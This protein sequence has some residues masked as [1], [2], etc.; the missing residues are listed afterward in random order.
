LCPVP[1]AILHSVRWNAA[2]SGRDAAGFDVVMT[3]TQAIPP[4]LGRVP[5]RDLMTA[6]YPT[7]AAIRE[8]TPAFAVENNGYRMWVITR[9]EDVRQVLSDPSVRRDLVAHRKEINSHCL[10]RVQQR[11]HLPHGSRRSF[12]DRDG[13]E[14][15][16]LRGL[17]GNIFSPGRLVALRADTERITAELLDKLPVGEPVDL[18]DR[19]ARP[20]AGTV[21]C[22]LVG[23]PVDERNMLAVLETEMITS[24]VITEIEEAAQ[25][26]HD[27]S[28]ELVAL[29]REQPRDDLF[30]ALLHRHDEG[31]MSLDELT[32]TYVLLLVGGME[33]ASAIGNGVFTLLTNPDQTARLLAD[34]SLFAGCVDEIVRYESPFRFVPPRYTTAPIELDGVTIPAGELLL[35][36]LA[37][38][39][40]DPARFPE[41]D[42]FDPD[43]DTKGHLGFGYGVHRCLGAELGRI[44]TATALRALFERF[45][46]TRL[47]VPP[48]DAVW[49][50][51]KF[52]R[53][54]DTLPVILN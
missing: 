35:I 10:V 37:A 17:V 21:I 39:N 20:L 2:L 3:T 48:D 41:P 29:K 5:M 23:V 44:E 1:A 7:L 11:A 42:S 22:D 31:R 46:R 32:S 50:P 25:R 6:P 54:L 51:G 49:R 36:S 16:R 14:H 43:R 24:P 13:D 47:T 4:V 12:F 19:F 38:A 45:P 40:R 33:P 34:P 15:R 53:R 28:V 27:F 9:Y 30:T 52:M 26:L 8:S 18:L